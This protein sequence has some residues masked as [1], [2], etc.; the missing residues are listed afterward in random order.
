MTIIT[1]PPTE[2]G[3]EGGKAKTD[4]VQAR[5]HTGFHRFMEIG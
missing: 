3:W 5:I 1:S 4:I 2:R